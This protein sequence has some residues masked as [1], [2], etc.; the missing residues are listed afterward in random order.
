MKRERERVF[1]HAL[2][3]PAYVLCDI[4]FPSLRIRLIGEAD[5]RN[6]LEIEK[7]LRAVR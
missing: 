1:M 5:K 7:D 4:F 6:V 3:H 2:C